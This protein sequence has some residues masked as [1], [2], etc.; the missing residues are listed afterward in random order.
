MI[1]VSEPDR[2]LRNYAK[3]AT[4]YLLRVMNFR[5]S[6]AK[7]QRRKGSRMNHDILNS[8]LKNNTPWK[9]FLIPQTP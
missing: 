2:T 6:H 9:S 8:I 7:A 1:A 5:I 3:Q 4:M